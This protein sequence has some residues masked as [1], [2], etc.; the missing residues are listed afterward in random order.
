MFFN[1]AFVSGHSES[2]NN[3]TLFPMVANHEISFMIA[4]SHF[5]PSQGLCGYV[6][7]LCM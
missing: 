7:K 4:D 1:E 6:K 5:N 2:W 3:F